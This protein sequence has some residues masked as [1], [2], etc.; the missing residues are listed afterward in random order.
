MG[1]PLECMK[2]GHP[3]YGG[4]RPRTAIPEK[5][6]LIELGKDLVAWASAPQKKGQP[7]RCR[8]CQWYTEKGF[9]CRQWKEFYDKPEFS[10]YYEKA[11]ALLCS[12]F[13]DGTIHPSIAN[14]YLRIY[15]PEMRDEENKDLDAQELRKASALKGEARAQEQERQKVLEEVNRNKRVPK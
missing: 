8:F 15:D 6:D 2:K 14:R 9:V 11:R 13:V 1:L 5:E 10:S 3:D 7:V 4:G 12:K